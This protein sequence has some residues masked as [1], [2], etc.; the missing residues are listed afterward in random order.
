M[1]LPWVQ[2]ILPE[3]VISPANEPEFLDRMRNK[4]LSLADTD[5]VQS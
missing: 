4:L 1:E 3:D 2:N 5:P